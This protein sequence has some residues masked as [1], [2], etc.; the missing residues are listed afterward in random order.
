MPKTQPSLIRAVPDSG[1]PG[2]ALFGD[3]C[4][5]FVHQNSNHSREHSL[6][7]YLNQAGFHLANWTRVVR[8]KNVVEQ[9]LRVS[10]KC[11]GD[12]SFLAFALAMF[13]SFFLSGKIFQTPTTTFTGS[14][15]FSWLWLILAG[16]RRIPGS[17]GRV[18]SDLVVVDVSVLLSFLVSLAPH[19][20]VSSSKSSAMCNFFG[21]PMI[22]GGGAASV[23]ARKHGESSRRLRSLF[24]NFG[25]RLSVRRFSGCGW[26]LRVRRVLS[27]RG[28]WERFPS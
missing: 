17:V 19:Y 1:A 10:A 24:P 14:G 15:T 6:V 9:V 20:L 4:S 8:A 11:T 12:Q 16:F 3:R 7:P 13:Q 5:C 26:F 2:P 25:G 21:W 18:D 22:E 23:S 27:I 28:F